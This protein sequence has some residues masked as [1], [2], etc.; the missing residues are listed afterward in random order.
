MT[1]TDLRD[2]MAMAA[3]TVA[4]VLDRAADLIE[5]EGAHLKYDLA[6]DA[7]GRSVDPDS[8]DAVSWC[9]AGAIYAAGGIPTDARD[10]ADDLIPGG[11]L[12]EFNNDH[13]QAE[14]V[15]ALRQAA[16]AHRTTRGED[17]V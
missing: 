16:Q 5:P 8:P 13:T 9:A 1:A 11:N 12:V 4:D 10:A 3:L 17:H 15:A 6:R 14:V 7:N 2:Q